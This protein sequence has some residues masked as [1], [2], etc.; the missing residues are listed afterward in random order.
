MR[1]TFRMI[2]KSPA[3]SAACIL[4][5][6]LGIGANTAMFSLVNAVLVRPLAFRNSGRLVWLWHRAWDR[7]RGVYSVPDFLDFEAQTRSLNGIT[8]FTIWGANLTG[9]AEPERLQGM[10]ILGNAFEVLGVEA[11]AGRT[12]MAADETP[13]SA[14]VV[15]LGDG[16]WRRRFG[17]DRGVIGQTLLLNGEAY[18]VVGVLPPDF[19]FPL[20]ESELAIP[21]WLHSD[22]RKGDRGERFLRGIGRMKAGVSVGQ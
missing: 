10:R 21:L 12:L 22:P 6:A 9:Q 16:L 19:I 15:V 5:L 17:G 1:N 4:T 2:R 11:Q 20:A 8:A 7:E 14:R 3:F 13:G 18:N